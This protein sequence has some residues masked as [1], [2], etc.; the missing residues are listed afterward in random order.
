MTQPKIAN[1]SGVGPPIQFEFDI[2]LPPMESPDVRTVCLQ[3]FR[4]P[5]V[6][7]F[8]TIPL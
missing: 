3:H 7:G 8:S 5:L 2:F 6:A 4:L 1:D